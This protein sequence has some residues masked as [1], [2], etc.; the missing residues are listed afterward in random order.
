M[1]DDEPQATWQW[2]RDQPGSG[3]YMP[4]SPDPT[5]AS[6]AAFDAAADI[7]RR[8]IN[9]LR[10]LHDKDLH[11]LRDLLDARLSAMDTDRDRLWNRAEEL[12]HEFDDTLTRF[13]AEVERRDNASRQLIEQRL[14]D[15]DNA[16]N[17]NAKHIDQLIT[18]TGR[19]HHEITADICRR[20]SAER[21]Y[22][23]SQLEIV[24]TRMGEKFSAVDEQF[25][26]SKTAVDAA[27]TA[28]K[29]AVNEQNKANSAAIK[30]SEGNTKEQLTSLGQVA[31]ASFKAMSDK[32]EDARNRLT[33]I[34]SLTR[35][36]KETGAENRDT[37]HF[38]QTFEQ[39][40]RIAAAS[41]QRATLS[42][43]VAGIATLVAVI[44]VIIPLILRQLGE[45]PNG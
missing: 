4:R 5:E 8:D 14:E 16:R 11:A 44:A 39:T 29:E 41:Q 35:G 28:Q 13:R 33:V 7:A 10:Q 32:I 19:Q 38:G 30:V 6:K 20:I 27:L 26:A 15:L 12:R 22:I 34:E 37:T 42:T 9:S 24:A 43:I 1:P 18:D 2:S 36:I 40:A 31:D 45:T 23:M 17:L 21:E 3:L 25:T